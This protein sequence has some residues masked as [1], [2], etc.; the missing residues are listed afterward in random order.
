MQ[1]Q[2]LVTLTR[3]RLL[4]HGQVY[5]EPG[6]STLPGTSSVLDEL[7]RV[8]LEHP[9]LPR[10]IIEGHTDTGGSDAVNQRISLARAES[11]LRY[12]V[13]KGVPASRLEARGFGARRPASS[14]ATQ[15]GR[16][17]NRRAELRLLLGEPAPP[18][19]SPTQAPPD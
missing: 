9:G 4:L 7:A 2:P 6:A 10:V 14:N 15:E 17:H 5:F 16:E 11:V 18:P 1:E 13:Q 3:E 12:L 8:L 19:P